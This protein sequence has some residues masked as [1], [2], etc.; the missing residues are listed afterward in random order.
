MDKLNELGD[1]VGA[2]LTNLVNSVLIG[3]GFPVTVVSQVLL[4]IFVGFVLILG[5][6]LLSS[7]SEGK[8]R[9]REDPEPE[10]LEKDKL[11]PMKKVADLVYYEVKSVTREII[12]WERT[13]R[14][15][16]GLYL[17][18][19]LDVQEILE[20][21]LL[22]MRFNGDWF[23]FRNTKSISQH[24]V[25]HM[26]EIIDEAEKGKFDFK[27]SNIPWRIDPTYLATYEVEI[28]GHY[29]HLIQANKCVRLLLAEFDKEK[30][31]LDEDDG[32]KYLLFEEVALFGGISW[33]QRK[34]YLWEG[35]R[36]TK[37]EIE[38]VQE[39]YLDKEV[40]AVE[41]EPKYM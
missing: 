19:R 15:L 14:G 39:L 41:L 33:Q 25:D 34:V 7:I 38:E 6:G 5:Y 27:W 17:V 8:T 29:S 13:G 30:L 20:K 37:E 35:D 11:G 9:R 2:W 12:E 22:V 26:D 36:L 32:D 18:E 1:M 16:R 40:E 31:E 28:H 24:E 21:G 3:L 23:F 10:E 4:V